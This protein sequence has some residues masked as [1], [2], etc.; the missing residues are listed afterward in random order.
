MLG[1][2]IP[3]LF[4]DYAIL[5]RLGQEF[6]DFLALQRH[7][8]VVGIVPIELRAE[9]QGVNS[10][11]VAFQDEVVLPAQENILFC[12]DLSIQGGLGNSQP[13]SGWTDDGTGFQQDHPIILP[14]VVGMDRDVVAWNFSSE[15]SHFD[16]MLPRMSF[17]C[18]A[19]GLALS[20]SSTSHT[21]VARYSGFRVGSCCVRCPTRRPVYQQRLIWERV[22][23]RK[24]AQNREVQDRAARA[25]G[26][27]CGGWPASPSR[28]DRRLTVR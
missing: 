5:D 15:H 21:T 4:F 17:C 12:H 13:F 28:Q 27:R 7:E 25:P 6:T 10:W 14:D 18:G 26:Q 19:G 23:A 20:R 1:R 11:I 9:I 16:Q 2:F 8:L 24:R 3:R 22:R